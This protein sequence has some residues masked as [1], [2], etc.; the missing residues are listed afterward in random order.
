MSF[1]EI[2]GVSALALGSIAIIVADCMANGVIGGI[3]AAGAAL[4]VWG[5]GLLFVDLVTSP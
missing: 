4:C 2:A 3:A 1:C 5:F